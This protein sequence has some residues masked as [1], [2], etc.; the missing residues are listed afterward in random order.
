MS[1]SPDRPPA[2]LYVALQREKSIT[3]LNI[4]NRNIAP[5]HMTRLIDGRW[6]QFG[7]YSCSRIPKVGS[8]AALLGWPGIRRTDAAPARGA[9]R[10]PS[11]GAVAYH[12]RC[13]R[14]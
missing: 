2:R 9:V 12:R 11:A 8:A 10:R 1:W 6:L 7:N 3:P 14:P 13:G 4:G 5:Q